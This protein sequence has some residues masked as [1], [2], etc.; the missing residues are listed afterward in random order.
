MFFL[1]VIHVDI[2]LCFYNIQK[3]DLIWYFNIV[4]V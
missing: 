3:N 1:T 4:E 2:N